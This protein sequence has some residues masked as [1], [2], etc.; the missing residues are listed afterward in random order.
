MKPCSKC[1][2]NLMRTSYRKLDLIRN[3]YLFFSG[4]IILSKNTEKTPKNIENHK[5]LST[6]NYAHIDK[7]DTMNPC[8]IFEVILVRTS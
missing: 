6:G 1:E 5:N 2:V 7:H 3:V 4:Q 8:S